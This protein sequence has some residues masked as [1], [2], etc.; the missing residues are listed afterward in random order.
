[1]SHGLQ[2]LRGPPEGGY[3]ANRQA[4]LHE[5]IATQQALSDQAKT[6]PNQGHVDLPPRTLRRAL[7]ELYFDYIHDQF[8]SMYHKPSFMDNMISDRV[9]H[10]VLFAIFAL[11]ARFSTNEFFDG[12]DPRERGEIFRAASESKCP[13]KNCM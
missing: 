8:H 9:P 7:V 1:M 11:A 6:S 5:N 12:T 13:C 2:C 10:V 4:R 3:Y